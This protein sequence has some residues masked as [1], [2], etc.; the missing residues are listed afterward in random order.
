VNE[1]QARIAYHR[2]GCFQQQVAI[3]QH[4]ARKQNRDRDSVPGSLGIRAL[5]GFVGLIAL[6]GAL[7]VL[8][9]R[10]PSAWWL[11]PVLFALSAAALWLWH[12]VVIITPQGLSQG[13]ML[14]RTGTHLL[15]DEVDYAHEDPQSSNIEIVAISGEKIILTPMHVGRLQFLEVV[16]RHCRIW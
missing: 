2:V 7:S 1:F 16:K 9:S 13:R 14:S 4:G 11:S 5:C 15:W 6:Y 8:L 3:D 10:D 12:R